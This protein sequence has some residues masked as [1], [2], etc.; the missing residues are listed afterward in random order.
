MYCSWEKYISSHLFIPNSSCSIVCYDLP[1][2]KNK[3]VGMK[4]GMT[5]F[6]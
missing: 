1:A 3:I 5:K 6:S 4:F 2:K